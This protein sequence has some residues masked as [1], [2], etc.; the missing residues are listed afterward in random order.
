MISRNLLLWLF[1]LLVLLVVNGLVLQKEH[2]KA[3][4]QVIL[5][6]LAPVDPRSLLQGDYMRLRYAIAGEAEDK[7][8]RRDGFI[9]ARLDAHQVAHYLR[10]HD[11]G[12]PLAPD[13]LLLPYRQRAFDLYIGP[14][15]FFFQEGH[16][17]YY[18]AARYG[19]LRIN[20]TGD[21]VLVGLRGDDFELLGPP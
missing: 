12:I 4:G 3:N 10:I 2:L 20:R 1:T 9:I 5:L 17:E 8:E 19:E 14:E 7:I 15:S 18:E 16:A 21:L 13:E 11:A 6:E